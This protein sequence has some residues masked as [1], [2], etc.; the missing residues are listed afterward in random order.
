MGQGQIWGGIQYQLVFCDMHDA[1]EV[2]DIRRGDRQLRMDSGRKG[3]SKGSEGSK[4]HDRQGIVKE[5][6]RN[7]I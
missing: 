6:F 7:R 5:K 2:L 4:S 3:G 1:K